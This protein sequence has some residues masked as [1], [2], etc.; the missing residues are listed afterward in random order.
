MRKADIEDLDVIE[1]A[2][3]TNVDDPR[4][5]KNWTTRA[6]RRVL[7]SM[8]NKFEEVISRFRPQKIYLYKVL[9]GLSFYFHCYPK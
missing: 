1:Y 9:L 8:N 4:Y 3:K 6:E 7:R 2:E 5:P